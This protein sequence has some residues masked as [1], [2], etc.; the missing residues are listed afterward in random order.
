MSNGEHGES[1]YRRMFELS[2][3]V[4]SSTDEVW[5]R[6]F[7]RAASS[8]DRFAANVINR[9]SGD[10][11]RKL[12]RRNDGQSLPTTAA[13]ETGQPILQM[14]A[15]ARTLLTGLEDDP[16]VRQE[17]LGFIRRAEQDT[18]QVLEANPGLRPGLDSLLR[19]MNQG[20]AR[21]YLEGVHLIR[22]GGRRVGP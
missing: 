3:D 13:S 16:Q 11:W 2:S 19:Y 15:E 6:V 9:T 14:D 21:L 8:G 18:Q 17:A 22:S 10:P 5:Q 20:V 4:P 7:E 12:P 1:Y